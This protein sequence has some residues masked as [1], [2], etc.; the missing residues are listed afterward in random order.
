MTLTTN[1]WQH[2]NTEQSLLTALPVSAVV[3]FTKPTSACPGATRQRFLTTSVS[4]YLWA[5]KKMK[6]WKRLPK[7]L[8]S[9]MHFS[10]SV[11]ERKFVFCAPMSRVPSVSLL[12]VMSLPVPSCFD[13]AA[14]VPR[15]WMYTVMTHSMMN[16]VSIQDMY[17]ISERHPR[18][19]TQLHEPQQSE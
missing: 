19:C 16:T 12:G 11:L 2:N 4:F 6:N 15:L 14:P 13:S 1:R 9:E 5:D 17:D 10:W 18:M 3:L 7:K 8:A